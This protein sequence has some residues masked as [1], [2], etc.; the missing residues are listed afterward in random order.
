MSHDRLVWEWKVT[1]R[2]LCSVNEHWLWRT[3]LLCLDNASAWKDEAKLRPTTSTLHSTL[4]PF[5]KC[6]WGL[7]SV[8]SCSSRMFLVTVT[9]PSIL[10]YC[11]HNCS[12]SWFTEDATFVSDNVEDRERQS[13][14]CVWGVSGL[15]AVTLDISLQVLRRPLSSRSL[16]WTTLCM[17]A[18][19]SEPISISWL[20]DNRAVSRV[21]WWNTQVIDSVNNVTVPVTATVQNSKHLH[22]YRD[23]DMLDFF[24]VTI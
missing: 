24:T 11:L 14:A 23:W 9:S 4:S 10:S 22:S 8:S 16:C 18:G 3:Q 6:T 17:A 15:T 12:S 2:L 1:C 5:L 7:P 13:Q 21:C 19:L 20:A